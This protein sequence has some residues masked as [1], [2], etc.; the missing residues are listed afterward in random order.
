MKNN[1]SYKKKHLTTCE[2]DAHTLA[3]IRP[4]LSVRLNG[5]PCLAFVRSLVTSASASGNPK[6][7]LILK[8]LVESI[9]DGEQVW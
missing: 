1:K 7:D 6:S 4:S 5:E 8:D 2:S 3:S 9:R